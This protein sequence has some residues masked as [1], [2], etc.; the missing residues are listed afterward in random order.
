[1]ATYE[2]KNPFDGP[3]TVSTHHDGSHP[4]TASST[5]RNVVILMDGTAN[6]YSMTN[7]NIIKLASV[8][9]VDR[10][11]L[12]YYDSGVGTTLPAAAS[13]WSD[14]KRAAGVVLD[15]AL[16][17]AYKIYKD[18]TNIYPPCPHGRSGQNDHASATESLAH[19]YKRTFGISKAVR[20][21]FLGVYDTVASLGM[22]EV[23]ELPFASNVDMV[24]FFRQAL[25][26]NE[27]RAKF[28]PVYRHPDVPVA[29]IA[30]PFC[31]EH[32]VHKLSRFFTNLTYHAKGLIG[33]LSPDIHS[34]KNEVGV[35]MQSGDACGH[36]GANGKQLRSK[37][38]WF[39]GCH[40]DVGGGNDE[41]GQAS[42]SNITF[43]WMLREAEHCGLKLDAPNVLLQSALDVPP[44]AKYIESIPN[45]SPL[46]DEL[47][48]HFF[49]RLIQLHEQAEIRREIESILTPD[50]IH[51]L[52]DLAA[53]FDTESQYFSPNEIRAKESDLRRLPKESLTWK[54]WI[55]EWMILQT[56]TYS[57]GAG[58]KS[59][60][61]GFS[62]RPKDLLPRDWDVTWDDL[63]D[64][65]GLPAGGWED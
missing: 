4:T 7:T 54:W 14:V 44:V 10:D 26:L 12:M 53:A 6:Q 52:I 5:G 61:G 16:A 62:W 40:S 46:V 36:P 41:N 34:E 57:G 27:R 17:C 1:M 8:I 28:Q 2:V 11:Q 24:G 20:V 48:Q 58:G 59:G 49:H 45:L 21:H 33:K 39:L 60:D 15:E 25:A 31:T 30:T 63:R 65:N 47:K 19:G 37:E 32:I 64:E 35:E 22:L 43:R 3:S 50:K 38:V 13:S 55:L 29:D 42:L 56:R 9:Q 23:K 51:M 18:R